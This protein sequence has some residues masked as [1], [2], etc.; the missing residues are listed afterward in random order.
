MVEEIGQLTLMKKEGGTLLSRVRGKRERESTVGRDGGKKYTAEREGDRL[1]AER[2]RGRGR[3]SERKHIMAGKTL[4][5]Y[6]KR[7]Y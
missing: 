6:A 2:G 7:D 3:A 4:T 1:Q 5:C